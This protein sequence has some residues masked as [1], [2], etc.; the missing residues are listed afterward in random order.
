MTRL[1]TLADAEAVSE[2][3]ALEIVRRLRARAASVA[4]RTWRSAAAPRRGAPTSCW[5]ARC[6]DWDA[7]R[8]GSP[9]SAASDRGTSRATTGSRARRCW[10]GR[11][12]ARAG[13]SHGGRARSRGRGPTLRAVAGGCPR[14]PRAGAR[15][16]GRRR[17]LPVLDVIVLG[18]GPDGHVASLFPGAPTLD[19]DEQALCLGVHDSP[20]PPP[21]RITLS[22]S[23][24]R[25]ARA[26]CCWPRARP[27]PTRSPRCWASRATRPREPAAAGP[28]ERDRRRR[29]GPTAAAGGEH[30][31]RGWVWPHAAIPS[32]SHA[33]PTRPVHVPV[34]GNAACGVPRGRTCAAPRMAHA[35]SE[36]KQLSQI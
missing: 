35:P 4:S 21:E 20:K 9:T 18:I 27:S 22:L 33:T 23:V 8:C 6:R 1:T 7:S 26:A 10:R 30:G 14:M 24:L 5:R 13:P 17:R 28:P 36:Q 19:A 32:G 11:R 29:R 16:R 25:A 34:G 12:P 2:R 31:L 15:A 3:A